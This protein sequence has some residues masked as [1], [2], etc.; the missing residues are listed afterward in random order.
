MSDIYFILDTNDIEFINECMCAAFMLDFKL[1]PFKIMLHLRFFQDSL[2]TLGETCF[3]EL[4][5]CSVL[6]EN[7]TLKSNPMV[8]R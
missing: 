5:I 1:R 7:S 3:R 8:E 6:K 4:P 2:V